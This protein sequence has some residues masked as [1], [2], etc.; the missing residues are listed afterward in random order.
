MRC[1][2]LA[3]AWTKAGGHAAFA[4]A[5]GAEDLQ[6]RLL[7]AGFRVARIDAEPGSDQDAQRTLALMREL[8]PSWIAVDG[9]HFSAK[10]CASLC[11]AGSC[12]LLVDDDG[13]RAPY[14]SD[15]VVNVNPQATTTLYEE[16]SPKTELLLGPRYALLRQEFLDCDLRARDVPEK[17]TNILVTFGGADP[18]NVTLQVLDALAEIRDIKLQVTAIVGA[19][20]PHSESI[21]LASMRSPHAVRML[22]DVRDMPEIMSQSDLII[23]AGGVTCF[24]AA[25]MKVPMFLITMA[26]NHEETVEAWGRVNA[27]VAAGWFNS[28]T[29]EELAHSLRQT[30]VDRKLRERIRDGATALVDGRGAAR[31]MGAMDAIGRE[32]QEQSVGH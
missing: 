13:G 7:A 27:A 6:G 14:R 26:D 9:F 8:N 19:S 10:Y 4:M 11:G 20:N 25:F 17:A 24:E 3:Q 21:K 22:F 1:I 18:H 15:L 31:V 5:E 30:I 32:R 29:K 16:R 23:T 2:S 12:V 28:M